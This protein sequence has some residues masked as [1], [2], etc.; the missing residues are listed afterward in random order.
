MNRLKDYFGYV[1]I[2][3]IVGL[4][5]FRYHQNQ[6]RPLNEEVLIQHAVFELENRIPKG[7][8]S[9]VHLRYQEQRYLGRQYDG[10]LESAPLGSLLLLNGKLS[11]LPKNKN[12]KA[13]DYGAYLQQQGFSG[14]ITIEQVAPIGQHSTLLYWVREQRL[15]LSQQ[16]DRMEIDGQAKGIYKALFLGL[17]GEIDRT[18]KAN[19]STAGLMHLLAVSGLHLG[20]IYFLVQALCKLLPLGKNRRYWSSLFILISIWGFCFISGAGPSVVRA[21]TMFS[22]LSLSKLMRRQISTLRLIVVSAFLLLILSPRL[23]R[24]AGFLLSYSA[25]IGIVYLVPILTN[26]YQPK[27]RLLRYFLQLIYV[28]IAAQLFTAPLSLYYFGSFPSYFLLANLVMLPIISLTMYL[29]LLVLLLDGMGWADWIMQ[30]Y[31]ELLLFPQKFSAWIASLPHAHLDWQISLVSS[32]LAALF[33][34]ILVFIPKSKQTKLPWLG[35]LFLLIIG[36]HSIMRKTEKDW[37]MSLSS[38]RDLEFA[39]RIGPAQYRFGASIDE[40]GEYIHLQDLPYVDE[41]LKLSLNER[42]GYCLEMATSSMLITEGP[43]L[44]LHPSIETVIYYGRSPKKEKSWRQWCQDRNL[45]FYTCR[46][47]GVIFP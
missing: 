11:P 31:S 27:Q 47:Q 42:L 26:S 22:I 14:I 40:E 16:I 25:V 41:H 33:L 38:G 21:A 19:F 6:V 7:H 4:L 9:E 29:G 35:G 46:E 8:Y 3:L 15:S 5:L 2:P 18:V 13:F 28:S 24:E 34:I 20:I 43:P 39:L 10:S 44:A 37:E 23:G 30:A 32:V 36:V 17:R 12:P 1:L 45:N